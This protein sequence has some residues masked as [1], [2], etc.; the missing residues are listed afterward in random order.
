MAEIGLVDKK[1]EK[2]YRYM[3][4]DQLPEFQKVAATVT[5]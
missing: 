1:A 2:I 4:F 3:N 5:I